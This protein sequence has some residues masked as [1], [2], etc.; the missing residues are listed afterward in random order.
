MMI[1]LLQWDGRRVVYSH[2]YRLTFNCSVTLNQLLYQCLIGRFFANCNLGFLIVFFWEKSRAVKIHYW[3]IVQWLQSVHK[4]P[5]HFFFDHWQLY[6]WCSLSL[7]FYIYIYIYIYLWV[8]SLKSCPVFFVIHCK[9]KWLEVASVLKW[10]WVRKKHQLIP[11][12]R[13]LFPASSTTKW[14]V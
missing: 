5:Y 14:S 8:Y 10:Y 6:L 9:S 1:R 13:T 7:S 3:H 11:S 4:N 2:S 12:T